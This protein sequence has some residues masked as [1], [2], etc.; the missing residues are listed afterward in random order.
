MT[1]ATDPRDIKVYQGS[2]DWSALYVKG[3]LVRVGDHYLIDEKIYE[4][5][6]IETVDSDDFMRGGEQESDVAQTLEELN[7][8][9]LSRDAEEARKREGVQ[10]LFDNLASMEPDD[11]LRRLIDKVGEKYGVSLKAKD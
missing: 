9:S 7:A 5:L 1:A 8:F 2:S 11:D 3:K 6:G 4:L 10:A